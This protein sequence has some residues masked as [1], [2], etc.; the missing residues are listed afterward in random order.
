MRR[1]LCFLLFVIISVG[2]A[3][4]VYAQKSIS[5]N[6]HI[7]EQLKALDIMSDAE[8]KEEEY[9]T[10]EEFAYIM[11]KLAGSQETGI[12]KAAELGYLLAYDDGSLQPNAK[13]RFDEVVRALVIV[14]G[15]DVQVKTVYG[16]SYMQAAE[17]LGIIKSVALL[18]D[19]YV[20]KRQMAVMVYESLDIPL[21][22]LNISGADNI[23]YEVNEKKTIL[24]ENFKVQRGKGNITSNEFSSLYRDDGTGRKSVIVDGDL[25][26]ET[27]NTDAEFLLGYYSEFLYRSE[28]GKNMLLWI[29]A[30]LKKN[31]EVFIESR[32]IINYDKLT[33]TFYLEGK[34]K[35]EKLS[36]SAVFIYNGVAVSVTE[37]N[38]RQMMPEYGEISLIDSDC[39]GIYDTVMIMDY[40]PS[41]I[42]CVDVEKAI[43][44][45]KQDVDSYNLE[46]ADAVK[47]FDKEYNELQLKDIKNNDVIWFAESLNK[48]YITI[49][50]SK[51]N[52][53]GTI[54]G[55]E[56]DGE[57]T[58][59]TILGKKYFV[60]NGLNEKNKFKVG[61]SGKFKMDIVG[62]IIGYEPIANGALRVGYLLKSM[63]D[64]N[65]ESPLILK[66]LDGETSSNYFCA[67]KIRIN[68]N[69]YTDY[70][71]ALAEL[72]ENSEKV[73][74]QIIRF[75]IDAN[76]KV[77]YIETAVNAPSG[78]GR[79]FVEAVIPAREFNVGGYFKSNGNY[80]ANCFALDDNAVVIMVPSDE[81]DYGSYVYTTP[82]AIK[83]DTYMYG[84]TAYKDD[85]NADYCFAAVWADNQKASSKNSPSRMGKKGILHD[86]EMSLNDEDEEIYKLTYSDWIGTKTVTTDDAEL[87]EGL[88]TG[89]I[90]RFDQDSITGEI[91]AL[92]VDYDYN[93]HS[94]PSGYDTSG[95][96]VQEYRISCGYV[97]KK[98]NNSIKIEVKNIPQPQNKFVDKEL[99]LFD[100]CKTYVVEKTRKGIEVRNG[101]NSEI[102]V[103]DKLVYTQLWGAT[104]TIFVYRF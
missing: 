17:S 1:I 19:S 68:D 38:K 98:Q 48:R 70:K 31:R 95:G 67:E 73:K 79:M 33:Y 58:I 24:S 15:Y 71:L 89:D 78:D 62:N 91:L 93:T 4:G 82:K 69:I 56:K 46:S 85:D 80:V 60:D 57:K 77:N 47:I 64:E 97:V 49:L 76:G 54:A 44:I 22:R 20:N 102:Q 50:V 86:V 59:V 10:R 40:I 83:D 9:I 74:K 61:K 12:K 103:G 13:I 53:T 32:D 7:Y 100:K 96:Y 72:S 23:G 37:L 55:V 51:E 36:D 39:N 2:G 16:G 94:I 88:E 84:I 45:N 34:R 21:M 3:S 8:Q 42:D 41:V 75:K 66:I 92:T 28:D 87:V 35:S 63:V 52:I 104:A 30:D 14:L 29:Y 6:K 27:G 65:E 81:E 90:I 26:L 25:E 43:I 5:V 99:L 18:P 11:C 101:S